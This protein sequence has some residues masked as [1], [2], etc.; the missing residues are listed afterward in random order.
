MP[1]YESGGRG[2][3]SLRARFFLSTTIAFTIVLASLIGGGRALA[4]EL[5]PRS[6]APAPI[7][8]NF[9][10]AGYAISQGSV[11]TDPSLPVTNVEASIDRSILG[12]AH[13]FG[14]GKRTA[15]IQVV[16]PYN[17]ATFSGDVMEQSASVKKWGYGDLLVRLGWNLIGD[18]ALK[19]AQFAR[20]K[21][22][23]TF[24][25]SLTVLAPTGAYNP[26][27][28]INTGSNRWAFFPE[29]GFEKPMKRWFLDGSAGAWLYTNNDNFL[30]GHVRSQNP[31]V[32]VQALY[33]YEWRP[34]LWVSAGAVYYGGGQT[35]VDGVPSHNVLIN[36]RYGLDFN[37]PI[38]RAFSAHL[39]WSTWLTATSGGEFHSLALQLQY[40]W[41]DR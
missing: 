29:V 21:P 22:S 2:F 17:A 1:D 8:A 26:S 38:S 27:R 16:L 19:P 41:F 11:L 34:G 18:P 12:Y 10:V 6:Y 15:N 31:V 7:G 5:T 13:T 37:A 35:S 40:R 32:D 33:G 14:L 9:L 24:G 28:L 30:N 39:K 4:Q 36:G 20:R 3:E 23:T 25:A